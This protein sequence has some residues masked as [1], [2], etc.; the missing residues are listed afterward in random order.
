MSLRFAQSPQDNIRHKNNKKSPPNPDYFAV[1]YGGK[2]FRYQMSS[3]E[4]HMTVGEFLQTGPKLVKRY[5]ERIPEDRTA[6]ADVGRRGTV[7]RAGDWTG[8]SRMAL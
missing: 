2:G 8:R 1:I 3:A 4:A 7:S 5:V 6:E